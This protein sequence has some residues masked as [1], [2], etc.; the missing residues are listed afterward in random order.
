MLQLQVEYT[1]SFTFS[2]LIL[3]TL[4][5][6]YQTIWG[7]EIIQG[8][9]FFHTLLIGVSWNNGRRWLENK[10]KNENISC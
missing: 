10:T 3:Q 6:E 9:N 7:V 8:W 4:F 2:Q 1:I 5:V